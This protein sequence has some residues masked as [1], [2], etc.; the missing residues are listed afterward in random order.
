[1]TIANNNASEFTKRSME[2]LDN[3]CKDYDPPKDFK[4]NPRCRSGHKAMFKA[5]SAKGCKYGVYVS[6]RNPTGFYACMVA[7]YLA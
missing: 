1:M 3:L 4:T 7:Y 2:L 5:W 6:A